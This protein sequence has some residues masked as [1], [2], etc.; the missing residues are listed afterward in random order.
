MGHEEKR[1]AE[2]SQ[3]HHLFESFQT[4][5]VTKSDG[6]YLIYFHWPT[7]SEPSTSDGGTRSP[8]EAPPA[9]P[10]S[11]ETRPTDV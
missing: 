11:P 2:N 10:W 6:R 8:A 9:E 3:R 7:A 1:R 5:V 4:E